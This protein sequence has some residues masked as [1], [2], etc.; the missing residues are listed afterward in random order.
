M[1]Q[2]KETRKH[3]QKTHWGYLRP[4]FTA[5][6]F[7]CIA[8]AVLSP[9]L[10]L[11]FR[12]F[13]STDNAVGFITS[14]AILLS[15]IAVLVSGYIIQNIGK[16][17][18]LFIGL[19]ISATGLILLS[20]TNSV[21]GLV[22]FY[23][24]FT[25]ASILAGYAVELFILHFTPRKK[26]GKTTGV[27]GSLCNAGWVLGPLVGGLLAGALGFRTSIFIV[28]LIILVALLFFAFRR[29]EKHIFKYEHK[30]KLWPAFKKYFKKP[31][32]IKIYLVSFGLSFSYAGFFFLP[33]LLSNQGASIEQIGIFMTIGFIPFVFEFPIGSLVDRYG[34]KIFF[35][36]GFILIGLMSILI[37]ITNN[38]ALQ[39]ALF[40]ILNIGS[41]FIER[42]QYSHFYRMISEKEIGLT[43]VF[44]TASRIAWFIT[45]LIA[46]AV[47]LISNLQIWFIAIGF[48]TFVFAL[49][50]IFLQNN[51]YN[52]IT[53][54]ESSCPHCKN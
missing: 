46:A 25:F 39:A 6:T 10:I 52:E 54:K 5:Q 9:F 21:T 12:D 41:S 32:F 43:T 38:F 30:I 29:K 4:I 11:Y 40:F 23:G 51:H 34:E 37:V 15:L 33:L 16:E 53:R 47:L 22:I 14:A 24:I 45:P 27:M 28:A 44:Y 48:A 13:V 2:Q 42:T 19:V 50:S 26:V 17:K 20:I 18:S 35:V 31:A 8:S 36:F 7:F 3:R 49:I 1:P